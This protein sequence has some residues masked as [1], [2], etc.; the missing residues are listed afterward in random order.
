MRLAR[1]D[2]AD[3]RTRDYLT[4]LSQLLQQQPYAH[5]AYSLLAEHF[6]R[7][8]QM[9]RADKLARRAF[10]LA[11][12]SETCARRLLGVAQYGATDELVAYVGVCAQRWPTKSWPI[13]ALLD[14]VRLNAESNVAPDELINKLQVQ[15]PDC[16]SNP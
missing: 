4:R 12:Q 13:M 2:V 6:T 7:G 16:Y 1:L 10:E 3:G 14:H 9:K 15:Y 11:P 8:G 5:E